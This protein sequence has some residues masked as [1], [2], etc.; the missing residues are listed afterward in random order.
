[1]ADAYISRANV[2]IDEIEK[3][4]VNYNTEEINKLLNQ[5]ISTLKKA[6][7]LFDKTNFPKLIIH[8]YQRLFLWYLDNNPIKSHNIA[9]NILELCEINTEKFYNNKI[10]HLKWIFQNYYQ[11]KQVF[12]ASLYLQQLC[13]LLQENNDERNELIGHKLLLVELLIDQVKFR[14]AKV[15]CGELKELLKKRNDAKGIICANVRLYLGKCYTRLDKYSDAEK[16]FIKALKLIDPSLNDHTHQLMYAGI[17]EESGVMYM[18]MQKF[19][20]AVDNF[21]KALPIFERLSTSQYVDLIF[22]LSYIDLIRHNYI[23]GAERIRSMIEKENKRV[24]LNDYPQIYHL[25]GIL[26]SV[27]KNYDESIMWLEKNIALM[28]DKWD[29]DWQ[30]PVCQLGEI[31]RKSGKSDKAIELFRMYNKAILEQHKLEFNLNG[32]YGL[33]C[34]LLDND[35][36]GLLN[37]EVDRGIKFLLDKAKAM[38]SVF[39]YDKELLSTTVEQPFNDLV[40][41][42]NNDENRR[43][44]CVIINNVSFQSL[45]QWRDG[46][47][48]DALRLINLFDKLNYQV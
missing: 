3:R 20:K 24:N 45:K 36:N 4:Q 17:L 47:N 23:K 31:Y 9:I 2:I 15:H 32:C 40:Y 26:A 39:N 48:V 7:D 29:N 33:A 13:I 10:L 22:R 27:M 43:G 46:S 34:S 14:E 5:A 19:D 1:M 12:L 37:D 16:E 44:F 11:R 42:M 25:M 8:S 41:A 6:T 18:T 28:K 21:N 30:E 35:K 38:P